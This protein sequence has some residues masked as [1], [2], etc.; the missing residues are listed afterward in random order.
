MSK[1]QIPL[2]VR[3]RRAIARIGQSLADFGAALVRPIEALFAWI[4]RML[5]SGSER[6][7]G[8][9][10]LLL[11]IVRL[12][13]WPFRS[14]GD[15]LASVFAAVVPASL[16]RRLA[17]PFLWCYALLPRLLGRLVLLA[18]KLNLD[19]V[20][21]WLAWLL[22][23][24]WYPLA[25]IGN[26]L[27]VWASTRRYKPLLW[28][29][30]ALILLLP[31]LAAAAWGSIWGQTYVAEQY[32]LAVKEALGQ[33]DYSRVQLYERK[34][35]QLGVDTN[36]TD[37]RT[38]ETLEKDGKINEAYE[39]MERL[40]PVDKPGYPN[41][42]FWIAQRLL[43]NKLDLPPN[44]AQR[45]TAIHLNHLATLGVKGPDIDLLRAFLLAQQGQLAE[46]SK[47]LKPLTARIP[48][49]ATQ[50]MRIDIAL[51]DEDAAKQDALALRQHMQ[52]RVDKGLAIESDDY[53]N[54][55]MA[56]ELLG[57]TSRM[58]AV[59]SDWL[60]VDPTNQVARQDLAAVNLREFVDQ[61]HSPSPAPERLAAQLRDVF[62]HSANSEQLKQQVATI[63]QQRAQIPALAAAFRLLSSSVDVPAPLSE[64]I[65]TAAALEGDW[66]TSQTCLQH[67]VEQEPNSAVAWNNLACVLYQG[68]NA[69]LDQALAAVN[70]A[71]ELNPNEY[72]FRETRGQIHALLSQWQAAVT[73]LEFALNGMPGAPAIHKSLAAAYE[74]LGNKELAAA[75]RQY[76]N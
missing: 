14:A 55:A 25:A 76:S 29:L 54:W 64:A 30:P 24:I 17:G 72:R 68:K 19:I 39:R 61:I 23:P 50:R 15:V 27:V 63:Y 44:E 8:I 53:Q 16:R 37:F 73:D 13:A 57:N 34:L 26:F 41:A 6:V 32:R 4:G 74:A 75:H 22:T 65:G 9:E 43:V 69:P 51:P 31:I 48:L 38:A 12:L 40:A 7:Q 11:S 45:L 66:G 71:I 35:S 62:T 47:L 70:K 60:K 58:R 10:T 3:L 36:L 33:K 42:H 18:E 59:L 20:F 21:V 5:L 49:A 67:A 1:Y 28:G 56:E 52:S 46:A 2:S